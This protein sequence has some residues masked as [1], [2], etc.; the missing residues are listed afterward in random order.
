MVDLNRERRQQE[1]MLFGRQINACLWEMGCLDGLETTVS[2]RVG[3]KES[4]REA[5]VSE[6][7]AAVVETASRA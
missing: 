1:V 2:I 4:S 5:P 6:F 7:G 3:L